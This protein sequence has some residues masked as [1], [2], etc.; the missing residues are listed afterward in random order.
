[1]LVAIPLG[2]AANMAGMPSPSSTPNPYIEPTVGVSPSSAA[3]SQNFRVTGETACS[4]MWVNLFYTNY[5]DAQVFKQVHA[6][7]TKSSKRGL[8]NYV[9]VV[10]VPSDAKPGAAAAVQG[11][12]GC[13]DDQYTGSSNLP[14]TITKAPIVLRFDPS[15]VSPGSQVT[16]EGNNCY[17]PAGESVEITV[18]G[19]ES[20]SLQANLKG[21][22]FSAAFT[23]A[24][25]PGSLIATTMSSSCGGSVPGRATL[26]IQNPSAARSPIATYAVPTPSASPTLTKPTSSPSPRV[27]ELPSAV[28]PS[29]SILLASPAKHHRNAPVLIAVVLVA[30]IAVVT[31]IIAWRRR[32]S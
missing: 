12:A 23:V 7:S 3:D 11:Q 25:T 27:S 22:T 14:V 4:I 16:L 5:D 10:T 31:S 32:T 8:W 2:I 6:P 19:A 26:A 24:S 28:T 15:T 13:A 17:D 9:G 18:T 1:M 29:P 21:S 30:M 20:R